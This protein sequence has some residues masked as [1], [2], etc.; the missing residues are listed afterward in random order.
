MLSFP[1]V[2]ANASFQSVYEFFVQGGVFMG[3]LLI[4]S[5]VALAVIILRTIALRRD[6]VMPPDRD[7]FR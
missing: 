7:L 3:L 5:W 6:L 4:C 2:L 1:L